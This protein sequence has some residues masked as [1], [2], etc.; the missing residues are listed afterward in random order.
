MAI[1]TCKECDGRVSDVAAVCP[2]CGI[3]L[4]ALSAEQKSSI[5]QQSA[6]ARSRWLGGAAFFFGLLGLFFSAQVGG[7]DAFVSTWGA[8]SWF[9]VGGGAWYI[10]AEIARNLHEIKEKRK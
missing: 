3:A 9:I 6:F 10:L 7:K 2:H 4:P 5:I 8:A 1:T